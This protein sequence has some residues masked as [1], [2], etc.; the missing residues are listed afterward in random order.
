MTK[1]TVWKRTPQKLRL[2]LKFWVFTFLL[3]IEHPP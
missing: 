2:T 3:E 1:H